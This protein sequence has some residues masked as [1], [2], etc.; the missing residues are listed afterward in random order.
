MSESKKP[1]NLKM[2]SPEQL[3]KIEED[4]KFVEPTTPFEIIH[5]DLEMYR[6]I[7]DAFKLL[8]SKHD[9]KKDPV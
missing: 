2:P 4:S 1:G 3:D 8:S 5:A 6:A 9:G 7:V